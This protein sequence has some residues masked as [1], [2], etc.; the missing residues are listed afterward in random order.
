MGK[1]KSKSIRKAT[2]TLNVEGVKFN[3]NFDK[4]KRIL[5]GLTLSKKLRN[6]MAGL[7]TRTKKQE[8]VAEKKMQ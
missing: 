8:M 7:F 3:E 4:N 5:E 1:T 6:Q 2:K